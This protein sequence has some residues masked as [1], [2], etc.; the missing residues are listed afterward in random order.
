MVPPG[1]RITQ[2]MVPELV[3]LEF[4]E[5]STYT[6]RETVTPTKGLVICNTHLDV[7]R[8]KPMKGFLGEGDVLKLLIGHLRVRRSFAGWPGV[9]AMRRR[10]ITLVGDR[11][12]TTAGAIG[13][14]GG[15]L[16]SRATDP[17]ERRHG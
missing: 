4:R 14:S 10:V 16:D 5:L 6:A 11:L 3:G 12:A 13:A 9:L 17:R 8:C 15:H 2:E 1:N 7:L